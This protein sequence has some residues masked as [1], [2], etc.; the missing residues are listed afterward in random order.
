VRVALCNIVAGGVGITLT[1]SSDV[2]FV[3]QS[4]VPGEMAQAA[5]RAHRIGQ[6][7]PVAVRVLTLAN[8]V[9]ASCGEILA[10]KASMIQEV[11]K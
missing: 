10:R 8:S 4:F 1:A 11:L 7:R 5:C 6:T 2:D 9:D 3:E